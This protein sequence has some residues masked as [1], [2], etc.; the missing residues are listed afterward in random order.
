LLLD[1][2]TNHLDLEMRYAVGRA[3]QAFQGA[4]VI[5]SHDRHLLRITTDEFWLVHEGGVE[6]FPG[7]LDDYPSWLAGQRRSTGNPGGDRADPPPGGHTASARKDRK[8][9]QAELRKRLQPLRREQLK[10][11][12]EMEKL[13]RRQQQLDQLLADPMLYD[14]SQKEILKQRLREKSDLQAALDECERHWL[15]VSEQLEAAQNDET[16]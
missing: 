11:E 1:E 15:A 16:V 9:Q 12:Q 3:L 7:S 8:R 5:V 6:P 10:F 2:P 14:P 13:H 4:M